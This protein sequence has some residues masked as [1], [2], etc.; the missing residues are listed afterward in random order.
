MKKIILFLLLFSAVQTFAQRKPYVINQ[1]S[2]TITGALKVGNIVSP[3]IMAINSG[4]A[5]T[6][7][8]G[9]TIT[10]N[11]TV[12]DLSANRSWTISTAASSALNP[13]AYQTSSYTALVNDLVQTNATSANIPILLPNAP[14]D[15]SIVGIKMM[16]QGAGF[17]SSITTQGS[18]VINIAGGVTTVSITYLNQAV[19]FQYQASTHIWL[20]TY[21]YTPLSKLDLRYGTLAQQIA[22]YNAIGLKQAKIIPA[23]PSAPSSTIITGDSTNM[24]IWKLQAEVNTNISA[25]TGKQTTVTLTTTGTSGV[26][27]FNSG[28][29]ALNIPQYS[30]GSSTPS[31]QA[32]TTVGNTS[33]FNIAAKNISTAQQQYNKI[34]VLGNSISFGVGATV[35]DSNYVSVVARGLNLFPD[36]RGVSGALSSS[37]FATVAVPYN[38]STLK[39]AIIMFDVNEF[40]FQTDTNVYKAQLSSLVDSLTNIRNIPKSKIIMCGG[41]YLTQTGAIPVT[42]YTAI[43]AAI[44]AAKGI[45]YIENYNY[46]LSNGGA[47]L[48]Y[49]NLHPN[50][51]GHK[52]LGNHI[53][54]SLT[55]FIN[56][57]PGG[58]HADSIISAPAINT[59]N[60]YGQI[61]SIDTLKAQTSRYTQFQ[62]SISFK[63]NGFTTNKILLDFYDAGTSATRTSIGIQGN[64][65]RLILGTAGG[66][67]GG[68]Y[69]CVGCDALTASTS[70]A[71]WYLDANNAFHIKTL[72]GTLNYGSANIANNY[73]LLYDNGTTSTRSGMIL[74]GGTANLGV[75]ANTNGS[76]LFATGLDQSN[77]TPSTAAFGVT[78]NK[79]FINNI[80]GSI[81]YGSGN[82]ANNALLLYY[83]GTTTSATGLALFGSGASLGIIS[84]VSGSI[85]AGN[86][87]DKSTLT[88]TNAAFGSTSNI[89][90]VN[91]KL[92]L[93]G[94]TS[95]V[96]TL[97]AQA[98]AGTYNWNYPTSAGTS[99]QFL[100]SGG[101]A[102]SPMTWTS[103]PTL[104]HLNITTGTNGGAATATLIAGTVTVSNTSV[105]ASSII[106]MDRSLS[107]GTV[108]TYTY[109]V[110][111][112]TGFTITS[113]SNTD[114]S[115][116]GYV[117]IN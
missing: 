66:G 95:G 5:A 89:F 82:V 54:A 44:A 88:V 80:S 33:T 24:A 112:G 85:V 30:G 74:T 2:V 68:M 107:G 34:L 79:L 59:K 9:R 43:S 14:A 19:Y 51:K 20:I 35:P 32:V 77:L 111:A 55:S 23:N 105:T 18:D 69:A 26:A 46:M 42:K 31:L 10:I 16:F 72:A 58:L 108:G 62:D 97:G 116:L 56:N 83:N 93:N 63:F 90:F 4:L 45:T 12:Y 81:S 101:G 103:T 29:G 94:T 96:I 17:T 87:F 60:L 64:G 104:G 47:T 67:S 91:N 99:G 117:I 21:E 36:N 38:S 76:V 106:L 22:N 78:G 71:G 75:I 65:E 70:N 84:N 41:S 73:Y 1:D 114:T 39:L 50:N 102:S 110:T 13:T 113:S 86:G 53:I 115:T 3:T 11:G 27:T 52:V 49:D 8:T 15:K 61:T 7:P 98:A 6:V 92:S 57:N 25:I 100:I 40:Y 37:V 48:M 28:T 109:T